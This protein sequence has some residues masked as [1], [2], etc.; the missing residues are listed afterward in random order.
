MLERAKALF[1]VAD[2]RESILAPVSPVVGTHTGPGTIGL[3]YM[4]GM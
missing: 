4:V 3:A 2:I 1:N